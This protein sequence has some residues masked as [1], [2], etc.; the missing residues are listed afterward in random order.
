MSIDELAD[1]P[2]RGAHDAIDVAE[3]ARVAAEVTALIEHHRG[4]L[5]AA[6]EELT[7]LQRTVRSEIRAAVHEL[8]RIAAGASSTSDAGEA[9]PVARES[10]RRRRPFRR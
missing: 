6:M 3:L 8:D 1:H 7:A 9:A 4:E 10:R 5:R 2:P